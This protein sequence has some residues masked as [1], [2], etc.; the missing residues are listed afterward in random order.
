MA[1]EYREAV[2]SMTFQLARVRTRL[3]VAA[4]FVL[5]LAGARPAEAQWP[6]V[7]MF[8]GGAL[9]EPVFVTGADSAALGSLFRPATPGARAS[10]AIEMGS[11]PYFDVACFWGPASD[12]AVNGTRRLADLEPGMAWQH[13]RF[14]PAVGDQP[15]IV[16]VTAMEKK[17]LARGTQVGRPQSAS[18]ASAAFRGVPPPTDARRFTAGGPVSPQALTVLE[19]LGVPTRSGA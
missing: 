2:T 19:R 16:F 7:L 3:S 6:T 5:L 10:T 1:R 8:H 4:T 14:Y 13:A 9:D 17:V 11:R 18:G 12:P 15:A